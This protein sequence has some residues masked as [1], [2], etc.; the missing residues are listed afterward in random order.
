MY[1]DDWKRPIYSYKT[2]FEGDEYTG[3]EIQKNAR[4]I[5]SPQYEE[6]QPKSLV[7]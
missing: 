1:I 4:E 5:G 3:L 7:G 6:K 2:Y